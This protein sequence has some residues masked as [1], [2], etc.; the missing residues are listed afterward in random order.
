MCLLLLSVLLYGEYPIFQGL[1]KLYLPM[2]YPL[3]TALAY[4][5]LDHM[6]NQNQLHQHHDAQILLQSQD[7]EKTQKVLGT[8]DDIKAQL[9][10]ENYSLS[11]S[12][13][14]D[15][16]DRL[17]KKDEQLQKISTISADLDIQLKPEDNQLVRGEKTEISVIIKNE[18]ETE[19]S[20]VEVDPIVP[21]NWDVSG[22]E[23]MDSIEAGDTVT[24]TFD[25]EVS[26][27]ADY[28]DPYEDFVVQ[29][30]VS[31]HLMDSKVEHTIS[32]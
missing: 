4:Q 23:K 9:Q 11:D 31:Y 14:V 8:V 1:Y 7:L 28:F 3:D 26:E 22:V 30:D 29:A 17:N 27:N 21:E 13:K 10:D 25:V 19:V 20:K 24:T 32:P 15:L 12:M 16:L 18:G 5:E 6:H 2:F